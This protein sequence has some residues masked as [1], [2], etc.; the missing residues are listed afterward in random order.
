MPLPPDAP[1]APTDGPGPVP[2]DN[3][4][5]HHPDREQDK[6]R[7][8]PPSP[9]PRGRAPA[10]RT[11][12]VPVADAAPTGG[13][14]PFA[15]RSDYRIPARLLGLTDHSAYVELGHDRL[16]IRFGRWSLSTP[17]ANVATATV[18]GPYDWWKVLGPPHISL[19]DRG[20]TFATSTDRGVC[21]TFHEPVPGALPVAALRHP[22]ATV[23][24]EDLEALVAAVATAVARASRVTV[25]R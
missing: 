22:G 10:D 2:A 5:G 17:I 15:I 21:I 12:D 8:P 19:A 20:V 23:T 6:P 14:F 25:G 7:L 4:P 11:R 18:T 9:S 16:T 24:V 1:G 3:L 13:R